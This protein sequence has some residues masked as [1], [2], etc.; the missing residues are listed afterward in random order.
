M[1]L[2]NS[3]LLNIIIIQYLQETM[4]ERNP[5]DRLPS[6]LTR[7]FPTVNSDDDVVDVPMTTSCI[8]NLDIFC[9]VCSI[10]MHIV[11]M[12]FDYNVAIQYLL[13][14]KITYFAWTI[15]LI[16]IPS[17]INVIISK[18]MH[19]QEKEVKYIYNSYVIL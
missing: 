19:S 18:R 17:L 16:I 5:E 7:I 10:L 6:Y 2:K 8:P 13:D 1:I 9:I 4:E 11:D 14:V 3:H 12:L 15:C